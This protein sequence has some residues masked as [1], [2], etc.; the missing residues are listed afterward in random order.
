MEYIG[1]HGIESYYSSILLPETGVRELLKGHV[2][3]LRID[4]LCLVRSVLF[5]WTVAGSLL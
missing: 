5:S 4:S 1:K 3:Y 2:F